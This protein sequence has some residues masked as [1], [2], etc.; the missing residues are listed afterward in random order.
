MRGAGGERGPHAC[1]PFRRPHPLQRSS[2]AL[3]LRSLHQK[4]VPSARR[5]SRSADRPPFGGTP[6]RLPSP[7][8]ERSPRWVCGMPRTPLTANR[9]RLSA[10]LSIAGRVDDRSHHVPGFNRGRSPPPHGLS[11]DRRSL[12][13]VRCARLRASGSSLRATPAAVRAPTRRWFRQLRADPS[14]GRHRVVAGSPPPAAVSVFAQ[15]WKT[16]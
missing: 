5:P 10:R 3:R 13:D 15:L 14:A 8:R 11:S 16:A 9:L 7:R 1:L 4:A 6:R 12:Q 2:A